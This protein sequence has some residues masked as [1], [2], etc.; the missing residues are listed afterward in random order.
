MFEQFKKFE[1]TLA[2]RPLVIETGKMA[3]LANGSC[4]VRYG[5]TAVLCTA[6]ASATPRDGIDFPPVAVDC[7]EK[8]SSVGRIPGSWNR[9]EGRPTEHA[10]LASRVID[11]P[12]RPLFPKDL[13]N[14]IVLSLTVMSVDQDCSP[15]IAAMFGA[16]LALTIS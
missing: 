15:E 14:D 5:E 12:I 7:E 16:S 9:R 6:T 4:L 3:Q 8:L 1:Y 2:G 13:R 10:I 11:R